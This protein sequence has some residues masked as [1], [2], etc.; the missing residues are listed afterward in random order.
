MKR[1]AVLTLVFFLGVC[2]G[3]AGGVYQ[4][5]GMAVVESY[6]IGFEHGHSTGMF[7]AATAYESGG[8]IVEIGP[9][10]KI[11]KRIK[12]EPQP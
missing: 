3:Y 8:E 4:W 11:A 5:R 7:D 9:D 12:K 1:L 10:G 6:H 2:G